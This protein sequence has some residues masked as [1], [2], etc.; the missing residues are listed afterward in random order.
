MPH[1][2]GSSASYTRLL[3][4]MFLIRDRQVFCFACRRAASSDGRRIAINKAMIAMTT[5]SSINVNAPLAEPQRR[6]PTQLC[7]FMTIVLPTDPL[8]TC[9]NI[10]C[11]N[12]INALFVHPRWLITSHG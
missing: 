12:Y 6:V 7:V 9:L 1:P 2:C 11:T 3:V 4:P 10:E 5:N 8:E